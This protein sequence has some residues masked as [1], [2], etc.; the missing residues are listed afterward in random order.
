MAD[1]IGNSSQAITLPLMAWQANRL[2]R[3]CISSD[4]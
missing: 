4:A 1:W 3:E 2:S